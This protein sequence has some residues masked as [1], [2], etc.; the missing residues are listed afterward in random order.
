MSCGCSQSSNMVGG[1]KSY[2]NNLTY[3]ELKS[4]A[5]KLEIKGRSKLTNKFDLISAIRK[6]NI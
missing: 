4:L 6:K 2:L 1:G 5:T 3:N